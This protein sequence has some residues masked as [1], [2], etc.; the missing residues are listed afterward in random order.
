MST[1]TLIFVGMFVTLVGG[2]A[3][4][5]KMV[6]KSAE[7]KTNEMAHAVEAVDVPIEDDEAGPATDPKAALVKYMDGLKR[8][9]APFDKMGATLDRSQH[10]SKLARLETLK[11]MLEAKGQLNDS[12][13]QAMVVDAERNLARYA[14]KS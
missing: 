5:V 12:E 13:V 9:I 3:M 7:S 8:L 4:A 6:L 1:G 10:D 14:P 2:A 11:K